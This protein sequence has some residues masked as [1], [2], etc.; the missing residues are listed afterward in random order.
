MSSFCSHALWK[1][2]SQWQRMIFC[3]LIELGF[4]VVILN[5]L[6]DLWLSDTSSDLVYNMIE[7]SFL[8]AYATGFQPDLQIFFLSFLYFCVEVLAACG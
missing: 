3:F 2:G 6:E 1:K 8:S 4:V 5:C 7:T